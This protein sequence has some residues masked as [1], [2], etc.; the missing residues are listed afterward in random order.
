MARLTGERPMEGA[1]PDSLLA[2]HAAG[3]REIRH[4]LGPGTVLDVGCGVGAET[5]ELAAPERTVLG[6]DYSSETA[7]AAGRTLGRAGLRFAAMDGARLGVRDDAVDWVCSSHII[8]HFVAPEQH[9][10]ELA[11]VCTHDGRV[12]VVTPN[13]P[14][15]FENPFHVY[16]FEAAELASMLRLFFDDVEVLGLEGSPE[17]HE[18]FARRRASGERLLKLDPLRIRHRV[19]RSWYV[20]GYEHVLPV[21]Y[22]ALGSSTTGIGSGIDDSHFFLTERIVPTTPGLFAMAARPRV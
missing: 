17:L 14:A 19:P 6:V 1:T 2:F 15:D 20:W 21:V 22:R 7:V 3:Y 11:R 4:H 16:L 9:V 8:E 13:R 5:A 10:A 12:F 18:D